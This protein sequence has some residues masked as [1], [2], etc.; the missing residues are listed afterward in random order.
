MLINTLKNS[1]YFEISFV[2]TNWIFNCDNVNL[3]WYPISVATMYLS[4][5]GRLHFFLSSFFT[6]VT[7]T[8]YFCEYSLSEKR[9][10]ARTHFPFEIFVE[11]LD[12]L[13]FSF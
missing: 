1:L 9:F 5:N 8:I 4:Y 10:W 2:V 6:V 7:M 3:F 12:G 11:I 13:F